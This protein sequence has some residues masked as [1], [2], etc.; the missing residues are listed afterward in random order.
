MPS[1]L[2]DKINEMYFDEFADNVVDCDGS[3][4][5]LIDD[6]VEDLKNL[7]LS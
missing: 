3:N 2:A 1:V 7:L 6:Y 5:T 4:I